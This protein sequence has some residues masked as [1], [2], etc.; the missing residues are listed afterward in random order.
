MVVYR[1][2]KSL[3]RLGRGSAGAECYPVAP[4]EPCRGFIIG[5]VIRATKRDRSCR[6]SEE[7]LQLLYQIS[8]SL[9]GSR[10]GNL[11]SSLF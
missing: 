4:L 5:R 7:T 2:A 6:A 10:K 11:P 3:S 1:V 8:S 9:S